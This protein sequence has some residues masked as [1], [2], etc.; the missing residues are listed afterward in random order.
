LGVDRPGSWRYLYTRGISLER[1]SRW[2]EAEVDFLAA[3]ELNPGQPQILNY[4]GYS[5]VDQGL[6]LDRALKMIE[7]AIEWDPSNGLVVDS[8]GWAFYRLGRMDEAVT[9]LEHAVQLQP[10]SSDVNDHL[11]D[12]YW[13][14]GRQREARFQWRIAVAVDKDGKI[15]QAAQVKL[16]EGLIKPVTEN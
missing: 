3:L 13:Q 6:H 9:V 7:E 15:A 16:A 8:L 4:L 1:A 12:A 14:V 5:W 11:G 10:N 2:P